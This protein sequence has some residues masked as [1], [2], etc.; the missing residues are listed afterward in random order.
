MSATHR[1][2]V[3][4]V[5]A[6]LLLGG[7]GGTATTTTTT[8]PA[9]TAAAPA[10]A[11]STTKAGEVAG[12]TADKDAIIEKMMTA[13]ST[14]KTFTWTSDGSTN[15]GGTETKMSIV[16]VVDQSTKGH[17]KTKMTM[18]TS[19]GDIV[20]I[21]D[22]DDYYLQMGG[23]WFKMD[24]AS[25]EKTGVEM[26]DSSDPASSLGDLRAQIQKAVFVGDE[27]IDGTATKHYQLTLDSSA[28]SEL[29]QGATAK[30]TSS[31]MPYDVWLDSSGMM[32]K[33]AIQLEGVSMSGVISKINEPVTIDIPT[34]AQKMPGT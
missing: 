7:C 18:G 26:P 15:V 3:L 33:F 14:V 1:Y 6:L 30:P 22:G 27:S 20:T 32:R 16:A 13:Y 17:T 9:G 31:T 4:A 25:I 24:K 23:T 8:A 19:A 29:G 28:L 10:P 34:N 11:T 12:Q 5:A 21:L 2:G